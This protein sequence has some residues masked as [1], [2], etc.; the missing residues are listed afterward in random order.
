[1]PQA[2]KPLTTLLQSGLGGGLVAE[3]VRQAALKQRIQDAL[4]DALKDQLLGCGLK[5][6]ILMLEW[7][8]AAA[9]NLGRF[10]AP[11]LM[12]LLRGSGLH[13]LKEIKTRTRP[14]STRP[15]APQ[16]PRTPPTEAV[17]C[18]L[19]STTGHMAPDALRDALVRLTETL[20]NKRRKP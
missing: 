12:E 13:E 10:H 5:Q 3:S 20:K 4:P 1:M 6:G 9:A 2:P 15:L 16:K 7:S 8:S 18:H 11:R 19:A 17:I 14:A